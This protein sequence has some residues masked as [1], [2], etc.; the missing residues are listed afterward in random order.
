MARAVR[1]RSLPPVPQSL[2]SVKADPDGVYRR[3]WYETWSKRT[4]MVPSRSRTARIHGATK[5]SLL[6]AVTE[7]PTLLAGRAHVNCCQTKSRCRSANMCAVSYM[8]KL[9]WNFRDLLQEFPICLVPCA[10]ANI[11]RSPL[12]ALVGRFWEGFLHRHI[13]SHRTLPRSTVK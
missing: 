3:W 5:V 2:L 11:G 10:H 1:A 9:E 7:V 13:V 6:R 8:S 4:G 12:Y